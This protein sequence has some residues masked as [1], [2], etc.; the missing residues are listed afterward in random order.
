MDGFL[1]GPTVRQLIFDSLLVAARLHRISVSV[2]FS[3]LLDNLTTATR[4]H[5]LST[6]PSSVQIDAVVTI[7]EACVAS[8]LV[9]KEGSRR[10]RL[11]LDAW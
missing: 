5:L 4:L 7:V 6:K 10:S 9:S 1:F 11:P 2:M 3:S 8:R